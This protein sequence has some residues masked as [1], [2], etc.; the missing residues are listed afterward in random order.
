MKTYKAAAIK[1]PYGWTSFVQTWINGEKVKSEGT[2]ILT[3][4]KKEAI[5]YAKNKI[6][7]LEYWNGSITAQLKNKRIRS[8]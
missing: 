5:D 1:L 3:A 7:L 4:T 2:E 8:I 6:K